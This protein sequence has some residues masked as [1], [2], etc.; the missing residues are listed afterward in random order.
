MIVPPPL[1]LAGHKDDL[2]RREDSVE[3]GVQGHLAV[4]VDRSVRYQ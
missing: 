1:I 2:R 4:L 3:A